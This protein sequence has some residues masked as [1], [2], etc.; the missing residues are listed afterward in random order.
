[1]TLDVGSNKIEI[2]NE[3]RRHQFSRDVF[4]KFGKL[5]VRRMSGCLHYIEKLN[6]EQ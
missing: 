6:Y 2:F 1:M 4:S 5:E 3:G